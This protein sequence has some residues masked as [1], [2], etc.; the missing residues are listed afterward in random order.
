MGKNRHSKDKI[1]ITATEWSTEYGGKKDKKSQEY[2]PLP[3]DRCAISFSE[4]RTPVCLAE[5]VIFDYESL[6][7]YLLKYKKNPITGKAASARDIIRL[8]MT[9]SEDGRC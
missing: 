4:Y 8:N 2:R 6:M 1:F 9:K 5:G 7:E 3:F